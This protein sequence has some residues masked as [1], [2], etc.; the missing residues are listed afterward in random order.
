MP[1]IRLVR[2]GQAS[3]AAEDDNVLSDPG[4]A[5][6]VVVGRELPRR[7]LR[8]PHPVSG[9]LARQ[10]ETAQL[11]AEATGFKQPLGQDPRWNE[12]DHVTLLDR[13]APPPQEPGRGRR[14]VGSGGI[15]AAP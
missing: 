11:V 3:F 15:L 4:H 10:R 6:A 12:Y 9:T 5:Q 2:H 13:Y 14:H 7:D 8:D 1:L